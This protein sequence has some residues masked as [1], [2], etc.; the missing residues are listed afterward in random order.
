MKINL[1]NE[2]FRTDYLKNLLTT[3]GVKDIKTFLDPPSYYLS[4]PALLDNIQRGAIWLEETLN[5]QGSRILIVVD[6]D[7]DGFTSGAIMWNYIR[8]IAPMQEIGFIL[9]QNKQHGLQ[10][11]IDFLLDLDKPFDL[12]ILP[13]SSSNDFEYHEA[14]GAQGVRCLVLDHHDLEEGKQIS[15]HACIINNQLSKNY[16]NKD[17]TGAGVTWQFCR[18]HTSLNTGHSTDIVDRLID[19]AALGI[20]GDMGSVLSL[21]N[22]YIMKQGFSHV[23]NYFFQQAIAKQSYSMNDVVNPTTV[24][25][26]IVP[27]MNAMI[28][29]GSQDEK[30]RLFMALIDGHKKIPCNKR[31]AKGTLEEAAIESL[32]EC[33]NAKAKQTRITDQMVERLEQKIFKYDLLENKILFIRLDED[34]DFPAEINGLIAMKLAA[35]FKRPAIVTRLNEEGFDRGSIRNVADCEL[36]D[37]K[38]FLN[39]S[40]YFEYVQG[41]PN[42]AGCSILDSNLRAFH[43]YANKALSHVDFNEGAYNVNFSRSE[44]D[45]DLEDLIYELGSYPELWGQGNPEPLIYVHDL[46]ILPSEVQIIGSKKDTLKIEKNN[47]IFMKFHANEMIEQ[48]NKCN[49]IKMNVVG[50]ANINEW[51]GNETAQIFIENW[52]VIDNLLEF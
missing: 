25:F 27:M 41:H 46:Y 3:R 20:C 2:N 12:I 22:R 39:E 9:H 47:V 17:L 10:D 52:E 7:V 28:R 23:T 19:L 11:H 44:T 16:P 38:A 42:A 32:R 35:R 14:L 26:Y 24:A 36:T 21:E 43:E 4:N 8:A 29:V 51:M 1:V 15:E 6:S 34:D 33:T 37:L 49:E 45:K 18:Y 31:G 40:G 30:E 48:L 13:D 5:K 50:R